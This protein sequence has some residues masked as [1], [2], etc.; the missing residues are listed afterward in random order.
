MLC[1]IGQSHLDSISIQLFDTGLATFVNIASKK[2]RWD[3]NLC[4]VLCYRHVSVRI[5]FAIASKT[6]MCLRSCTHCPYHGRSL[7]PS[8]KE[9][10]FCASRPITILIDLSKMPTYT[11]CHRVFNLLIAFVELTCVVERLIWLFDGNSDRTVRLHRSR[12]TNEIFFI[13]LRASYLLGC[14]PC[15]R[16]SSIQNEHLSNGVESTEEKLK[17]CRSASMLVLADFLS[18]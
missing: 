7:Q 8:S 17:M 18:W 2:V 1:F 11:V 4:R 16:T 13:A 5:F 3:T 10:G 14:L 6:S 12:W 9:T 15:Q